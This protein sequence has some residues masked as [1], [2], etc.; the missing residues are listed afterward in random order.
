MAP[1]PCFEASTWTRTTPCLNPTGLR[2][3]GP[4]VL[5]HE[6][7]DVLVVQQLFFAWAWAIV[8]GSGTA[9]LRLERA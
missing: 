7:S 9:K 6:L 8:E 3:G 5:V 2:D 1:L 4:G